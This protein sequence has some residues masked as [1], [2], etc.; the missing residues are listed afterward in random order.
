MKASIIDYPKPGLDPA[1]WDENNKLRTRIKRDIIDKIVGFMFKKGI[2]SKE[3][4]EVIDKIII[5]GSL[6]SYQWHSKSDL[7]VHLHVNMPKMREILENQKT[8]LTDDGIY[9]LLN[10]EWKKEIEVYRVKGTNHPLEYYF[11]IDG[12]SDITH[13]DGIYNLETDEWEQQPRQVDMTFD[14][15]M[16]YKAAMD[17][18]TNIMKEFDVNLADIKRDIIDI[19]L[20]KD[21][22]KKF[23]GEEKK[24]F[25][26]RLYEKIDEIEQTLLQMIDKSENIVDKR[27]EDYRA[28]SQENIRFKTL[29]KYKYIWLIKKLEHELED[30]NEEVKVKD[31]NDLK[32]IKKVVQEFDKFKLQPQE[33][34]GGSEDRVQAKDYGCLMLDMPKEKDTLIKHFVEETIDKDNLYYSKEFD[35]V[36]G[37]PKNFHITVK[38]GLYEMDE[39]K[40]KDFYKP[41]VIEFGPIIKFKQLEYDVLVVELISDDLMNLNK[42]ICKN[43]KNYTT[44]EYKPHMT[45]AYVKQ[46][47]HDDLVGKY[48]FESDEDKYLELS[49]YLYTPPKMEGNMKAHFGVPIVD[50]QSIPSEILKQF[51]LTHVFVV[52]TQDVRVT[53]IQGDD[54]LYFQIENW[55][56]LK[57]EIKSQILQAIKGCRFADF[58][59]DTGRVSLNLQKISAEENMKIKAKKLAE[60]STEELKDEEARHYYSYLKSKNPNRKKIVNQIREELTKHGEGGPAHTI[61]NLIKFLNEQGH[62]VFT[63]DGEFPASIKADYDIEGRIKKLLLEGKTEEEIKKILSDEPEKK[64]SKEELAKWNKKEVERWNKE[65]KERDEKQ[66]KYFEEGVAEQQKLR[67][68]QKTKGYEC[69]FIKS[70]S[71]GPR[72]D[73]Y[74][75]SEYWCK[76]GDVEHTIH[77][78]LR[79]ALDDEDMQFEE[80]DNQLQS[81]GFPPLKEMLESADE[82]EPSWAYDPMGNPASYE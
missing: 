1:I 23:S 79:E 2:S 26:K 29:Q 72:H 19:E 51:I 52:A 73:P 24:K 55:N 44:F 50:K 30:V 21:S 56:E 45:L 74:S 31:E 7:D 18:A 22:V 16:E 63:R 64:M 77:L 80:I 81:E 60:M 20:I 5:I 9:E 53:D 49:K 66:K 57:P 59:E 34:K 40:L 70:G 75:Y 61:E 35:Y 27:T 76:K 32:K 42:E 28:E 71:E 6:T 41:I 39:S 36:Q 43:F 33:L 10:K 54:T 17:E 68:E 4:K 58:V 15:E 62:D 8:K 48:I 37:I 69:E 47:A 13:K 67:D 25:K 11:E 78:G 38:F 46:G 12:I 82:I 3:F 65:K 14:P